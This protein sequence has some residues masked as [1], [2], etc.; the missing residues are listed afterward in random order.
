MRRE[1]AQDVQVLETVERKRHTITLTTQAE[2]A[3]VEYVAKREKINEATATGELIC[4]YEGM[5]KEA[6]VSWTE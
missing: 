4:F 6:K 3:L 1:E 5:V 2:K